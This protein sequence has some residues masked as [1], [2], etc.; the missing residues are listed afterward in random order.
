MSKLHF[1]K[2]VGTAQ[3]WCA[4]GNGELNKDG[5]NVEI[6]TGT[7]ES[8]HTYQVRQGQGVTGDNYPCTTGAVKKGTAKFGKKQE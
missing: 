4:D 7:V 6:T 1:Y 3:S 2:K 8:A 5:F